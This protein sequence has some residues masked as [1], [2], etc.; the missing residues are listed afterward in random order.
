MKAVAGTRIPQGS[1][2]F[3]G[4]VVLAATGSGLGGDGDPR[5]GDRL[6]GVRLA[7]DRTRP[8]NGRRA[9]AN[10]LIAAGTLVLSSGGLL[11]GLV[12]HDTVP[13][14]ALAARGSR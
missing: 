8:G 12:G 6:V 4:L 3:D 7:R 10:G 1:T 5:R 2:T 11:Q 13:G 14:V 9:A